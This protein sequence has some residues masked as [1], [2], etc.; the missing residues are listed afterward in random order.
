MF[1]KWE[2]YSS[3]IG[4]LLVFQS[5]PV[6][7]ESETVSKPYFFCVQ[8]KNAKLVDKPL[9]LHK[10]Y[11]SLKPEY[12]EQ[13]VLKIIDFI[14]R[15]NIEV[16]FKVGRLSRDDQIVIRVGSHEDCDKIINYINNDHYLQMGKKEASR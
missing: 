4:G 7:L 13:G 14:N 6:R 10:I 5:V 11:F 2:D 9:N 16:S 15:E 3:S 12:L 1:D 8:T